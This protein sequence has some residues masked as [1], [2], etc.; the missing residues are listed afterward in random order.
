[1]VSDESALLLD[2]LRKHSCI[3]CIQEARSTFGRKFAPAYVA[4]AFGHC[5]HSL[6]VKTWTAIDKPFDPV[7]PTTGK[8]LNALSSMLRF[9]IF[10]VMTGSL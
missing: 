9:G 3:I 2:S 5:N 8:F 7:D 4:Y 10:W 6:G 1:M